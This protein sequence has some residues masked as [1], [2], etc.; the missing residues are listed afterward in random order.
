MNDNIWTLV[1]YVMIGGGVAI[2]TTSGWFKSDDVTPVVDTL[3]PVMQDIAVAVGAI[4]TASTAIWGL[5]VGWKTKRVPIET[6]TVHD[7]VI[8]PMSGAVEKNVK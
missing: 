2:A 1:R 6:L 5:Y 4:M 8:N 3:I 7:D